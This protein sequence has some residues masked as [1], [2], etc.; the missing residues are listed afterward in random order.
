MKCLA[1]SKLVGTMIEIVVLLS[2]ISTAI[3]KMYES[4]RSPKK[5]NIKSINHFFGEKIIRIPPKIQNLDG[6][7][8]I[9]VNISMETSKLVVS[10][11]LDAFQNAF[12]VCS[13]SVNSFNKVSSS[14]QNVKPFWSSFP[15]LKVHSLLR[16]R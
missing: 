7:Y 2:E 6:R 3:L 5:I 11:L 13:L 14:V 9:L 15:I 12:D 16:M 4:K 1:I 8:T 10:I